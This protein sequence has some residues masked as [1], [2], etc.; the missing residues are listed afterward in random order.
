[1]TFPPR[2][3]PVID[4]FL[5]TLR[6][7][8]QG[9]TA[10]TIGGSHGKRT[11][12]EKSDVDFRV[13]CDEIAGGPTYWEGPR[14]NALCT[15]VDKWK[16]KDIHVDHCWVRTVSEIEK[17]LTAW[18][19]GRGQPVPR[20]WSVWGYHLPT[21]IGN[22]MIIED[23]HDIIGGWQRRMTPYPEALRSAVLK[24]Y[25]NSLRYWKADYHYRNKVERGD[26]LFLS[27]LTG[28]L[29]QDICQILFALNGVYYPGD[30]NNL[31][32]IRQ[33]AVKPADAERRLEY[34][35]YP[36]PG[37]F[38]EQYKSMLIFIDDTLGLMP[39]MNN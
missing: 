27:W 37:K 36:P 23:E 18:L 20:E 17:D 25:G 26:T 29:V 3:Q 21:D 39:K 16:A 38:Q 6:A 14:W 33:F 8:G 12:D 15:L 34:L 10:I 32:Y 11:S 7:F 35:L 19:E 31:S 5:P 9:R 2:I 24:K 22:Q 4:D 28:R 1:M 30:G 13:F